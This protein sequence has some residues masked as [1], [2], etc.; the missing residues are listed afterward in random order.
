[1]PSSGW[2]CDGLSHLHRAPA[3]ALQALRDP[4]EHHRPQSG[5]TA[6]SCP[7]GLSPCL[8]PHTLSSGVVPSL[9]WQPVPL[10][11]KQLVLFS[12]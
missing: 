7:Q 3:A 2:W 12:L 1:M 6:A 11:G 4:H 5:P 10:K 8:A 9:C